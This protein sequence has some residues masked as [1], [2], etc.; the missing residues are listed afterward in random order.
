MAVRERN[1]MILADLIQMRAE[2][3]P[4]LDVLTFEHL[5][6]DGGASADE[7]RTY[8]DFATNGNRLAAALV[9]RGMKPGDRFALMMRNHPEFVEAMVAASITGCVFV[10][11]DPRTRG[12]KLTFMLR[13]AGCRGVV[14]ADY[15]L[16]EALSAR[17]AVEGLDWLL[18]LDTGEDPKALP[19]ADA[20][21]VDSL[22]EALAKPAA[23]LVGL[24]TS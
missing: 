22:A 19:I 17:D 6:L 3:S 24:L 18:A 11:I 14:C 4:D 15:C 2:E 1:A 10:P 21:G 8:A 5:S 9:A 16:R 23:T 13:N 7:V 12:E 20:K